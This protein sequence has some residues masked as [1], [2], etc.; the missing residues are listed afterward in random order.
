MREMGDFNSTDSGWLQA[1]IVGR[2]GD[3]F[4][5]YITDLLGEYKIE[6]FHCEDIYMTVAW[7]AK[8][9]YNGN[10]L[11]IGRL[12]QL[13]AEEGKFLQKASKNG[14]LCCC[15][16]NINSSSEQLTAA[17]QTGA[18]IIDEQA[19]I[20]ETVSRLLADRTQQ[21]EKRQ[22]NT[23]EIFNKDEFA[24]TRTELNALLNM[25]ASAVDLT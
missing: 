2:P 23:A 16:A 1:V 18:C 8:N 22:N 21:L 19:K 7:L 20:A 4:V 10:V 3:K 5:G 6:L 14:L 11:V 13:A 15:L 25:P 9:S 24:V 12:E 17:R